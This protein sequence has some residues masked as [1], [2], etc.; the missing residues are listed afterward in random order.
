MFTGLVEALGTVIEIKTATLST[1]FTLTIG[2]AES[3]LTDVKLG[4][5]IAINGKL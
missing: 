3:I 5:S 4:D 2:D 1:G